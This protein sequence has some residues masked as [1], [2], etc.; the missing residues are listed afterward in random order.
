MSTDVPDDHLAASN[1]FFESRLGEFPV[2]I[3]LRG[4]S[5]E[6]TIALCR[7]AWDLG[8][9]LVEIPV[10]GKESLA[11]LAAAIDA[12]GPGAAVGAGTVTSVGVVD[13]VAAVGAAFTVAPGWDEQVARASVNAGMPHLPGVF[14]PTEVHTVTATGITWLKYFPARA[15][16]PAWLTALHGPFPAAR[17]VA[18][19]GITP[20]NAP[21]FLT[22]GAAAVSLGASFATADPV[23][24]AQLGKR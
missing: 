10:Q 7:L 24:V 12:A 19:G 17:F 18:T 5:V 1:A 3:I 6:E 8:I 4:H 11:A 20:D 22:A 2:L 14:T 16:G 9:E 13:Q 21:A 15:L 23:A